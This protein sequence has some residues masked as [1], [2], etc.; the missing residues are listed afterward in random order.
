M[1][2]LTLMAI[3]CAWFIRLVIGVSDVTM[4]LN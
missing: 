3:R 1:V 4:P 2:E